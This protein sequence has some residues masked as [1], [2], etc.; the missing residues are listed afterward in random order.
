[1]DKN[2]SLITSNIHH[3]NLIKISERMIMV[4][5]PVKEIFGDNVI[6]GEFHT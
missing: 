5:E 6:S 3:H 4:K 1:M 2:I